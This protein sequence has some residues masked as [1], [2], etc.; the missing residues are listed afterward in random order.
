LAQNVIEDCAVSENFLIS[1]EY[2]RWSEG[3]H[4]SRSPDRKQCCRVVTT[5]SQPVDCK[6]LATTNTELKE[7]AD[8]DRATELASQFSEMTTNASRQQQQ[9]SSSPPPPRTGP[10]D[11]MAD[12]CIFAAIIFCFVCTS[13]AG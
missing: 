11:A 7:L 9:P 12:D 1:V 3:T 2:G 10:S 13:D 6:R 4:T 8:E 5:I